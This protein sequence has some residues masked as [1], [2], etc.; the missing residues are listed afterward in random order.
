MMFRHTAFQMNIPIQQEEGP[1]VEERVCTFTIKGQPYTVKEGRQEFVPSF[2]GYTASSLLA[3][4][5][6]Q[7]CKCSQID[8]WDS[9]FS[10]WESYSA[11][12]PFGDYPIEPGRVYWLVCGEQEI[13][14]EPTPEPIPPKP[15]VPWL[16][17]LI[18]AALA[19]EK[20]R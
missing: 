4:I 18:L 9:Q 13:T 3:E 7:G 2:L 12:L 20:K 19:L 16:I 5:N 14:P 8:R 15:E 1:P 6:A 11:G 10:R 17:I